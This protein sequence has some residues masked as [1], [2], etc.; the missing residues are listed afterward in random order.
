M[1][2]SSV[3]VYDITNIVWEMDSEFIAQQFVVVILNVQVW[4]YVKFVCCVTKNLYT[5][6]K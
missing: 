1:D 4:H 3:P 2:Q 5:L 6:L